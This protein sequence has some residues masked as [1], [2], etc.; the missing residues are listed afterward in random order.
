MDASVK[1][2]PMSPMRFIWALQKALQT[3]HIS[4]IKAKI[5]NAVFVGINISAG[6]F[7]EKLRIWN[8]L[9]YAKITM[10]LSDLLE[11]DPEFQHAIGSV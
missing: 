10:K 4:L 7:E 6:Q 2:E 3:D 9:Y 11:L 5:F 8:I 1:L